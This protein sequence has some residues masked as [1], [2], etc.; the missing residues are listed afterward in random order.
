V[1]K[2]NDDVLNKLLEGDKM[3]AERER[4]RE[5]ER[6]LTLFS[7]LYGTAQHTCI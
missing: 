5:R 4:E 2:S 6:E 1:L 3:W 7:Y